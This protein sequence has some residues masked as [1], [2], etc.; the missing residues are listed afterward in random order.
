MS[1]K[2]KISDLRLRYLNYKQEHRWLRVLLNK[3]SVVTIMFLIWM[4]FLD[5]NN[6]GVWMRTRRTLR[7]QERSIVYL[8]NQIQETENRLYPLKSVTDSLERFAREEYF[9]H[10]DGEDVY[11][12]K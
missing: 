9:F 3:Y 8:R 7:N 11:I 12:V 10:E 6:I 1:V 2:G 4:L 5:N